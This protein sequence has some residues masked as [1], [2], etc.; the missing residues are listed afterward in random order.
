MVQEKN[1]I[2]Q[3]AIPP[4]TRRAAIIP[5]NASNHSHTAIP[6]DIPIQ[7]AK[8]EI[9]PD[10]DYEIKG[11]S[12]QFIEIKLRPSQ[13]ITGEVT[14]LMYY[15]N[16]INMKMRASSAVDSSE[17][18]LGGFFNKLLGIGKAALKGNK[19]F[20]MTFTNTTQ[21]E[22]KIAF[23]MPYSGTIIP[24]NLSAI[25]NRLI[26][27]D[28]AFLCATSDLMISSATAH[29]FGGS[30]FNP[31]ISMERIEGRGTVFL[32]CGGSLLE[33]NVSKGE[34]VN[35]AAGTTLAFQPGILFKTKTIR[36]VGITGQGHI[37][38]EISGAGNVWLQSL[39]YSRIK[40]NFIAQVA[41]FFGIKQKK[42]NPVWSGKKK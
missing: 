18:S 4:A 21:K 37:L 10:L 33:R 16:G 27:D 30:F 39:P 14:A 24:I 20:M 5:N 3:P 25:G 35:I 22:L 29:D 26:C 7:H 36:N 19:L 2:V 28:A 15:E 1:D 6:A 12:S 41:M 31:S 40:D 9:K 11:D 13:A 42:N 34:I 17:G 32:F 38:T 23:S 8:R